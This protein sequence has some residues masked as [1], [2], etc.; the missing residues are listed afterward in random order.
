MLAML[1]NKLDVQVINIYFITQSPQLFLRTL[2]EIGHIV[3]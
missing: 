1:L 3:V 2:G